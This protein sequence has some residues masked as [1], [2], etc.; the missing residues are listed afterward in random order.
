MLREP[1]IAERVLAVARERAGGDIDGLQ[2]DLIAAELSG[3]DA[4]T[5]V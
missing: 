4:A 1:A 2:G 3:G 5:N